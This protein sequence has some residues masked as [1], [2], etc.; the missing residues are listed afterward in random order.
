MQDCSIE[1]KDCIARVSQCS[2]LL[3]SNFQRKTVFIEFVLFP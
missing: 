3:L 1:K 2:L